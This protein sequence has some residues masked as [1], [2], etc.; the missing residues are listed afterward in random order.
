M[1]KKA[2][3]ASFLELVSHLLNVVYFLVDDSVQLLKVSDDL[4]RTMNGVLNLQ[5]LGNH[6][7]HAFVVLRKDGLED[8]E[9]VLSHF[10]RHLVEDVEELSLRW[11]SGHVKVRWLKAFRYHVVS[12]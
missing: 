11:V 3:L 4:A 5:V 12:A 7:A 8:R 10:V 9:V 6:W 2:S 1:L